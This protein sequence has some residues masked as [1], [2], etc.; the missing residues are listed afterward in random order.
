MHVL[1]GAKNLCCIKITLKGKKKKK[2]K[3]RYNLAYV[4]ISVYF[5]TLFSY[6]AKLFC[7][8]TIVRI[9]IVLLLFIT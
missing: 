1:Y 8:I 6:N 4:N 7:L 2:T 9:I 5:D 3:L